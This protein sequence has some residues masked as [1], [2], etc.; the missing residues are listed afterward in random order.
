[1]F[2]FGCVEFAAS[3]LLSFAS[4]Y[5]SETEDDL[6]KQYVPSL[7]LVVVLVMLKDGRQFCPDGTPMISMTMAFSGAYGNV[8]E[9]CFVELW[10]RVFCQLLGIAVVFAGFVLP[11]ESLYKHAPLEFGFVSRDNLTTESSK[12]SMSVANRV[13]FELFATSVECVA[14]PYALVP[15]LRQPTSLNGPPSKATSLAPRRKDLWFAAVGLGLLRYILQ[16]VCRTTMNP[17]TTAMHAF[18]VKA[19]AVTYFRFLGQLIGLVF[20]CGWCASF[21]P[22]AVSMA[23]DG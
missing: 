17:F 15:L 7:A 4:I 16:R 19:E 11:N 6:M 10:I 2:N 8:K 1:M 12:D 9:I 23:A 18:A 14:V 3:M 22:P 21:P 5:V 20:A 13:L